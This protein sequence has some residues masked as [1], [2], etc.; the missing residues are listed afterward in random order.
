MFT[1]LWEATTT[2]I[3]SIQL[4]LDG[5]SKNFI[6]KYFLKICQE[7]STFIIIWQEYQVLYI[8]TNTHYWSYLAQFFLDWKMLH[9]KVVN[10][11]I[12]HIM[13]NSFFLSCHL[14]DKLEKYCS[15]GQATVDN[16]KHE[17]GKLHTYSYKHTLRICNTDCSSIVAW[18]HLNITL[19][20]HCL[21]C[22]IIFLCRKP[23]D[24]WF[25]FT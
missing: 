19:Y 17:H 23:E 4:P 8:K 1:K 3:M 18:T 20:V 2:F 14:W 21:S 9:T 6:L 22:S 16:M 7:N 24:N 25:W 13:F 15:A 10:K 11:I 12:T 5:F